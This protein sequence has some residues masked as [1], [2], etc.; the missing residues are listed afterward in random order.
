MP[1]K[2][3]VA[4]FANGGRRIITMMDWLEARGCPYD[5]SASIKAAGHVKV[6]EWLDVQAKFTTGE[7][8]ETVLE[9]EHLAALK[10]IWPRYGTGGYGW[11]EDCAYAAARLGH[12]KILEWLQGSLNPWKETDCAEQSCCKWA[13]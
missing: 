1:V 12:V 9:R 13:H 5:W 8:Y 3:D 10:W 6:L 2:F 4:T 7:M 11:D